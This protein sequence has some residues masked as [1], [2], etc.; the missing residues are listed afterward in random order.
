M[1]G[2]AQIADRLREALL[3]TMSGEVAVRIERAPDWALVGG[4][5]LLAFVG[6]ALLVWVL[7]AV[8][9]LI[10][11]PRLL[12]HAASKRPAPAPPQPKE[13]P[14]PRH[15]PAGLAAR[16]QSRL[17]ELANSPPTQK[18][19]T[20]AQLKKLKE[21]EQRV[22][23]AAAEGAPADVFRELG[24]MRA[25]LDGAG[26]IEAF[27]AARALDTTDFW[28]HAFL[29]RL[30]ERAGRAD[31][32]HQ[33]GVAAVRAAAA[34]WQLMDFE[35]QVLSADETLE[36]LEAAKR[37]LPNVAETLEVLV[38]TASS[39]E[40]REFAQLL[41]LLISLGARFVDRD[42]RTGAAALEWSA[43][44]AAGLAQGDARALV[45]ELALD[46]YLR[47]R[48]AHLHSFE[49]LEPLAAALA[50]RLDEIS[51]ENTS[52]PPSAA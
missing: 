43:C 37:S 13:A 35:D 27:E 5:A 22:A 46:K 12:A 7:H 14:P 6:L 47:E 3:R 52:S 49:Q 15:H 42:L 31:E 16:L 36:Q 50:A 51:G 44:L 38:K 29:A 21:D 8:Y 45:A 24:A 41:G 39:E 2:I 18:P 10:A 4:A 48:L 19:P 28:T 11:R 1:S 23:A 30:Y 32:A 26:A 20:P 17:E 25:P 34:A 40:S 33:E 9:G